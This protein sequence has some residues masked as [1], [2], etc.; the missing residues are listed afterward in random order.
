MIEKIYLDMDGVLADFVGTVEGPEF[1]NG[2]LSGEEHYDE[3]KKAFTERG[4]FKKLT[5][6]PDMQQLVD[7][8]KNTGVTCEILTCAGVINHEMVCQDKTDWIRKYVDKD[9]PV[10]IT[11]KGVDKAQFAKKGHVLI[12]DRL[13]NINAWRDAGGTGILHLDAK[14]S[15][16]HLKT[17]MGVQEI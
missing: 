7:F 13:K 17:L 1:L 12:D 4:L 9:M 11:R 8:V 14:T 10:H 16:G 2:P 6:L 15:N 3:N 5:P